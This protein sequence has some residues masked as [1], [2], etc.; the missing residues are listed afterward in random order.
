MLLNANHLGSIGSGSGSGTGNK[1]RSYGPIFDEEPAPLPGSETRPCDPFSDEEPAPLPGSESHSCDPFSDGEP[2]PLPGSESH[3]CDYFSDEEPAP[4]DATRNPKVAT[5]FGGGRLPY[6]GSLPPDGPDSRSLLPL[7]AATRVTPRTPVI[8]RH[9]SLFTPGEGDPGPIPALNNLRSAGHDARSTVSTPEDP[10]SPQCPTTAPT[11]PTPYSGSSHGSERAYA[12]V[13]ELKVA[14]NNELSEAWVAEAH[15]THPFQTHLI[16]T[17]EEEHY[18]LDSRVEAWLEQYDGYDTKHKSWKTIKKGAPEARLYEPLVDLMEKI[19]EQFGQLEEKEAGTVIK[20]RKVVNTHGAFMRHNTADGK[21]SIL[22]TEPDITIF[23]TGPSATDGPEFSKKPSYSEAASLW[24][25]K[26]KPDFTSDER[27]QVACYAREVL[28]QQPNRRFVYATLMTGNILRILRFDRAGC[29][30]SQPI[31]FHKNANFFVKLVVLLGSLNEDLLGF[32]TS[33]TWL[34]GQRVL[35][36]RPAELFNPTTGAWEANTE[37]LVF[38]LASLPVFARRTIRSRGTVCWDAEYKGQHYIIKDYWRA[39]GR[40]Y[41]SAFLKKLAGIKGVGQMLAFDDDRETIK[42]GRGFDVAEEM[43]SHSTNLRV[44]DRSFMRI[45][46][47]KYGGTLEKAACA[48]DLLCAIRDIVAGHRDGLLEQDILHRD[49]S[50]SNIRLSPYEPEKG[51]VIDWDL[52]KEMKTLL[53]GTVTEDDSRTGTRAYQSVK[54]LNGS[55]LL[56]HHDNMD[57]IESIFYVL[58][59]VLYG[60]D[61]C[62]NPHSE[63]GFLADWGNV[64][65]RPAGLGQQK[66]AF[67][68]NPHGQKLTRYVGEEL[69]TLNRLVKNLRKFFLSRMEQIGEAIDVYDPTPF[70]VYERARA[71]EDYQQFLAMIDSAIEKLPLVSSI[72]ASARS[73]PI[74]F[75]DLSAAAPPSP[76]GSTGSTKRRRIPED[77]Q[78]GSSTSRSKRTRAEVPPVDPASDDSDSR[79]SIPKNMK[80]REDAAPYTPSKKSGK[81]RTKR[82]G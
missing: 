56:G 27:G 11:P 78:D 43:Y 59:Y 32:D 20:R 50:F 61:T 57:D 10:A 70:P 63:L 33:I 66:L 65:V 69:V 81:R 22:K 52:A 38:T 64:L 5:Q 79:S 29:Y 37:E 35:K 23:G 34:G 75:P 80:D 67:I 7:S 42:A 60:F 4:L 3:S 45:V 48:R 39:D 30:Y 51:V 25:I 28:I 31:D 12:V 36:M 1:S 72:P 71:D 49:I 62:G 82:R 6:M 24:E 68:Q 54:V 17:I 55:P 47:R 58:C 46:L 14:I 19:L 73:T 53:A 15:G 18:N 40:A 13:P 76:S 2:A 21:K 77:H 74:P 44:L 8:N 16:E 26:T 41:E 9:S